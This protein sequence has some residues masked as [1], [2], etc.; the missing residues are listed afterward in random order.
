MGDSMW[1]LLQQCVRSQI[2]PTFD[3][4]VW[5]EL[6]VIKQTMSTGDALSTYSVQPMCMH[7]QVFKCLWGAAALT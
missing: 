1:C 6:L 2:N 3:Y 7:T 4:D 5:F